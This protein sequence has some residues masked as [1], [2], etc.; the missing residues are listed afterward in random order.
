MCACVCVGGGWGKKRNKKQLPSLL[1]SLHWALST[2]AFSLFFT[3]PT[4]MLLKSCLPSS[5]CHLRANGKVLP[6]PQNQTPKCGLSSL[7]LFPLFPATHSLCCRRCGPWLSSKHPSHSLPTWGL[8]TCCSFLPR[9]P[10]LQPA[11]GPSSA[12]LSC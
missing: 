12:A 4:R 1:L 10:L 2:S 6:G 9:R 5:D 8:P 11:S 3:Q 7:A